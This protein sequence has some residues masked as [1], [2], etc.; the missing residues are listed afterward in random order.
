MLRPRGAQW[1]RT[2]PLRRG[3]A[4]RADGR[5]TYTMWVAFGA[6][7]ARAGV[8]VEEMTG[9]HLAQEKEVSWCPSR[10]SSRVWAWFVGSEERVGVHAKE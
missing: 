5:M 6:A 7:A 1:F 3:Y 8:T 2:I 10:A 4:A 9:A